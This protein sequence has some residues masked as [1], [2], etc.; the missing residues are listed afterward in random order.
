MS[1]IEEWDSSDGQNRTWIDSGADINESNFDVS[2]W[3]PSESNLSNW[4]PS[5]SNLS[6]WS[7][8]ESNFAESNS[9]LAS[10]SSPLFHT[11]CALLLVSYLAPTCSRWEHFTLLQK[12][13]SYDFVII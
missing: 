7:S 10:G 8:S 5:E 2:N 1:P 6:N 3:S 13:R 4:S 11:A 9:S 12:R